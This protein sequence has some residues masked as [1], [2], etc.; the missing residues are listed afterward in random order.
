MME[1]LGRKKKQ[2]IGGLKK[3]NKKQTHWNRK[4][5][6][7]ITECGTQICHQLD[8]FHYSKVTKCIYSS[9]VQCTFEGLVYFT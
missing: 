3:K 1:H 9:T 2:D 6:P 4:G 8:N 7:L 5:S